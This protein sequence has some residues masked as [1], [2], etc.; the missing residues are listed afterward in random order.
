MYF[1]GGGCY[2]RHSTSLSN[3]H[4]CPSFANMALLTC[5]VPYQPR[6]TSAHG[7][8]RLGKVVSF[9]RSSRIHSFSSVFCHNLLNKM[10]W[11]SGTMLGRYRGYKVTL[12]L[13]MLMVVWGA[14]SK[15][16]CVRS[17]AIGGWWENYSL[18]S[19]CGRL[20]GSSQRAT[21][22]WVLKHE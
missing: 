17:S 16:S 9:V 20:A 19:S 14:R 13:I 7:W 8:G 5:V 3:P 10:Y 2:F 21:S 6:V 12:N 11:L 4:E 18:N 1:R 22:E 15:Q